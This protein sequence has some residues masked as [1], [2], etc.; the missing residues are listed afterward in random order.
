M[1]NPPLVT[2]LRLHTSAHQSV[3]RDKSTVKWRCVWLSEK[4]NF[5]GVHREF[6]CNFFFFSFSCIAHF[7][8]P[9]YLWSRSW[10]RTVSHPWP[11]SGTVDT[12]KLVSHRGPLASQ[13][14]RE[15]DSSWSTR[16]SSSHVPTA[17]MPVEYCPLDAWYCPTPLLFFEA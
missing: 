8:I 14:G 13:W 17:P 11:L 9:L 6:V 7:S 1:Q 5:F 3:R 2:L 15:K 10:I 4:R 12:A 16:R